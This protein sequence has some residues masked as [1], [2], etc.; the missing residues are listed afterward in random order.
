MRLIAEGLV[1]NSSS[2][3]SP[4]IEEVKWLK[5]VRPGDELSVRLT[6]LET[7]ESKSRPEMGF[8]RQ[9][10]E[11]LNQKGEVVLDSTYVGMFGKRAAEPRP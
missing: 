8:V 7:R 9:R 4:G 5:P 10:G 6:V 3:G 1:L 2:M 11:M